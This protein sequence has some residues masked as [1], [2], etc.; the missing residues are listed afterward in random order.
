M[1]ADQVR[2]SARTDHDTAPRPLAR[3]LHADCDIAHIRN[4]DLIHTHANCL[5]YVH[6]CV[7]NPQIIRYKNHII[8]FVIISSLRLLT[9]LIFGLKGIINTERTW[10]LGSSDDLLCS[11]RISLTCF[12]LAFGL[13]LPTNKCK[14]WK[15]LASLMEHNM[16]WLRLR[17]NC[18]L[19]KCNIEAW[20]NLI[21]QWPTN[22]AK[23]VLIMTHI[24]QWSGQKSQYSCG[25]LKYDAIWHFNISIWLMS[26]LISLKKQDSLN[27]I[28]LIK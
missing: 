17:D 16:G 27:Y 4:S 10:L 28:L 13:N 9:S 2:T 7:T 8:R 18:H 3:P 1:S 14:W 6:K 22:G 19:Q 21:Y 24:I 5:Y 20:H 26:I 12:Y 11:F 15:L 23:Y 25:T